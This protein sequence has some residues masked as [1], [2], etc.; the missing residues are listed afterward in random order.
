MG[1]VIRVYVIHRLFGG[2]HNVTP[3]L[4]IVG[5]ELGREIV[6]GV[7]VMI[8]LQV[9][10]AVNVTTPRCVTDLELPRIPL[11][12]NAPVPLVVSLPTTFVQNAVSIVLME[13]RR[14][15]DAQSVNVLDRG[16]ETVVKYVIQINSAMVMVYIILM[17]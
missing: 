12:L 10:H 4:E 11:V 2:D 14:M 13:E 1:N 17:T 7:F 5:M 9:L 8:I 3:V 15:Q 16:L 6:V